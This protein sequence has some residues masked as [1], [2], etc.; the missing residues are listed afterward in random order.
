MSEEYD[1]CDFLTDVY[2]VV[3]ITV[4][5][6]PVGALLIAVVEYAFNQIK[7]LL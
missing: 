5:A 1:T 3:A 6:I 2:L 7:G 4:V